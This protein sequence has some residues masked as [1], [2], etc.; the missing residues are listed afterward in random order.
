MD[1]TGLY[2]RTTNG[3]MD[4]DIGWDINKPSASAS[5]SGLSFF[6]FFIVCSGGGMYVGICLRKCVWCWCR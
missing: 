2:E 5:A 6:F 4:K 1:L 3:W